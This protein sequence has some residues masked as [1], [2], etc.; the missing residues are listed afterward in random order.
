MG[1]FTTKEML[2]AL[3]LRIPMR[4]LFTQ[5]FASGNVHLADILEVEYRK[6]KR[7]MAPF[8]APRKGGKVVSRL[9]YNTKLLKTPKIAPERVT[10]ADDISQKGFGENI[11]STKSPQQRASELLADDMNDLE[12]YIQRR[13]EW[14][15]REIILNG[16]IRVEDAEEGVDIQVD[17]GFDNKESLTGTAAW[18]GSSPKIFDDLKRW[19]RT[20]IKKTGLAPTIVIMASDVFDSF[21]ADASV[22]KE[23]NLVNLKTADI[24][25]RV[26]DPALTFLG[27]IIELDLDVYS[28]DEWFIDDEGTEQPMLPEGTLLMLPEIIGS[29][30]YGAVTQMENGEFIT[31]EAEVVPKIISDDKNE[32]KVLRLTSRPLPR[33]YDVD[34][35]FVAIVQ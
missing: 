12:E 26:V 19:R 6:G 24:Q 33:P 34:G 30:E 8:V 28:Y 4:S 5:F 22:Q 2:E 23:L 27:R 1:N 21:K 32:I 11:Y 3:D 15:C 17:F 25:P 7:I 35:W 10:T 20:V 13:K 14:M 31:Y 16:S 18:N 9:G 29:I